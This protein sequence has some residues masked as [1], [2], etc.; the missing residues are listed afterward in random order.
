MFAGWYRGDSALSEYIQ[1]DIVNSRKGSKILP[2][3]IVAFY[4]TYCILGA[5]IDFDIY[6]TQSKLRQ[7][8]FLHTLRHTTDKLS[9][10]AL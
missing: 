4:G 1:H 9:T 6:H 2:F 8:L 10:N 5:N 7:S 3:K